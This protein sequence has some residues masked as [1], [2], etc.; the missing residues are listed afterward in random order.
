MT[1]PDATG[2][3]VPP[4]RGPR[5]ARGRRSARTPVRWA[6]WTPRSIQRRQPLGRTVMSMQPGGRR[7]H[8]ERIRSLRSRSAT[9]SR[10]RYLNTLGSRGQA[11]TC[12]LFAGSPTFYRCTQWRDGDPAPVDRARA[13]ADYRLPRRVPAVIARAAPAASSP[14]ATSSPIPIQISGIE[15][16]PDAEVGDDA[17]EPSAF[18]TTTF[19]LPSS[20]LPRR[21]S[22]PRLR[23]RR[24]P[25][26]SGLRAGS[27]GAPP[28]RF[29]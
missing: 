6:R 12:V 3:S 26:T 20:G 5:G 24:R 21:A 22:A 4:N 8:S 19:Q 7:S 28:W 17:A 16:G 9:I 1:S 15:L 29:E 11:H 23:W 18:M 2:S 10:S 13:R 27:P 14:P 25:R